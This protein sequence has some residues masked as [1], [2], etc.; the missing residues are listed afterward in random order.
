[1]N[2]RDALKI[3]LVRSFLLG[4]VFSTLLFGTFLKVELLT[5][6][7]LIVLAV[8]VLANTA[9]LYKKFCIAC[10]FSVSKENKDEDE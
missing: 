3:L 10:K 2:R 1:M 7:G 9:I 4:A 5:L 6:I 8:V